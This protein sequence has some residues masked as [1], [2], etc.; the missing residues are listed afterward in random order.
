VR[1][2]LKAV[3]FSGMFTGDPVE[4]V[5]VMVFMSTTKERRLVLGGGV[6]GAA[7]M[8]MLRVAVLPPQFDMQIKILD[9]PLQ[10]IR[11][12]AD[13]NIGKARVFRTFMQP[14]RQSRA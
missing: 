2:T 4:G 14:P 1:S 12:T 3:L 10:E 7:V 8:V 5:R 9:E 11:A 6:S 13:N